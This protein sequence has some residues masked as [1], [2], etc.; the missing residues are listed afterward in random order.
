MRSLSRL[1]IVLVICL[2]AIVLPAAPIQAY[3]EDIT[4]SP[5]SGV[6][7]EEVRIRGYNFTDYAWVDIYYY[8]NGSSFKIWIDDIETD[9]DGD[10]PWVT[11]TVPESCKGL[12]SVFVDD[13][14]GKSTYV[15]FTV[16]PGLTVSLE[17]GTVGTNVTVE[18][19]GFAEDEE[20]IELRYYIDSADYGTIADNIKADEFGW[21]TN[22]FP[23]PSSSKGDHKIDARGD[24]SNFYEVRDATFEVTPGISIDEPSGSVGDNITITGNGF[25]TEERDIKILFA[26]EAVVTEIRADDTG[27]WGESFKVPEMSIGTYTV[28]ADGE[29]TKK[30]DITELSFE[31]KPD[32]AL[33]PGEGHVGMNLTVTGRGFNANE[34]ID[35]MYDGSKVK[36]ATADAKGSF[37]VSFLVPESRHGERQVT[38]GV[39]GGT[40]A[41]AIFTMESASP[42]IPVLISPPDGS[43]V[44]FVGKMRPIFEWS[45]VSD[46]SGVYYSLQIAT[47]DNVTATGEFVDPVVSKE[48]LV[49]TNYTLE[50][51]EALP[52]GTYYWIVQAV[53]GAENESGWTAT[54]SFRSGL[55][56]LW[57]FIVI[58]IAIVG[59]IGAVVYFF[60]IKK[61]LY[62]Y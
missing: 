10:F 61:R 7:G 51:T 9:K 40:N 46:D 52:Y 54:S 24:E 60:I 35:I 11:F 34:D 25:Y 8:P 37:E 47:S 33:S 3:G 38:A 56:P 20:D 13:N 1:L 57:A 23:I 32:I 28:T 62:Y 17:E 5:S 30:E 59:V 43:R 26:G 29:R 19:H 21:W 36:T 41:T 31:I 45:E 18:G 4:L 2:V 15:N 42:P 58:I 53:D 27:Y 12:H 39:P 22:T 14:K 50:K 6:P 49:G 48:G 16:K 44:G 55:L